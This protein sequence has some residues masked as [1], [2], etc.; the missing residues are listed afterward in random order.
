M[1]LYWLWLT[2]CVKISEK[3]KWTLLEHFQNPEN[4]FF[5]TAEDMSAA[6]QLSQESLEQL[7]NKNLKPAEKIIAEC[8]RK[9]IHILTIDDDC[10]PSRLKNIYDPPM[11]L[12][13]KGKLIDFDNVATIGVVGTRDASAYGLATAKKLG[14]EIA[15]CG[16]VV[17]SGMALGIDAM[18]THGALL[19]SGYAVG[20]LGCG[21]DRVYPAGNADLFRRMERTGCLISEYCP[22]TKP[23]K[24]N[25]PRRNRIISGLACGT[26]VVEA[27]TK[28]GSLITA[29]QALEQGRDVFVVP[30]NID[31]PTFQGNFALLR[32]GAIAVSFGKDILAEY[33]GIYPNITLTEK[34]TASVDKNV[35]D[36]PPT[37]AYSDLEMP[38]DDLSAEEI[39]VLS[40]IKGETLMDTIITG[41]GIDQSAVMAAVTMLEIKGHVSTLPGGRVIRN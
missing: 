28:S 8:D 23:D 24:W 9:K 1:P 11:V 15:D 30:G 40:Q 7:Q 20:V 38:A 12:Y 3:E 37:S 34:K 41:T 33:A 26:V 13:Y 21:V 17:I 25:F 10:Y 16:G 19:S 18:A 29:R 4:I 6:V 5:A 36:N 32:E 39:A 31:V 14:G 2:E 22:G 35:V 27:P